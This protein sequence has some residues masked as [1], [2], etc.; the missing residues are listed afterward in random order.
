MLLI[1]ILVFVSRNILRINKEISVY[2]FN[3]YN[4]ASYNKIFQ[5]HNHYNNILRIKNCY[6]TKKCSKEHILILRKF[7]KDVFYTKK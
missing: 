7:N 1:I 4:D 5:N 3:F 2:N 6:L